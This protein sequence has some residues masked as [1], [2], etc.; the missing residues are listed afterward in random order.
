MSLKT[1]QQLE[2]K[3]CVITGEKW[4]RKC[5]M[6]TKNILYC[7]NSPTFSS[8]SQDATE[9]SELYLLKIIQLCKMTH[10]LHV[11]YHLSQA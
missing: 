3:F 5:W 7:H 1:A 4:C 6:H 2:G 9:F 10:L 11:E 8:L